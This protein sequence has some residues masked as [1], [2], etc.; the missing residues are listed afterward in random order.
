MS[1]SCGN[2][3]VARSTT[4]P[5]AAG[6]HYDAFAVLLHWLIAALIVLQVVLA[7]RMEGPRTP[8][9]FAV[10][11]LHK[12]IGIT[13]LLLSLLRLGWRLV[14]PPPPLPATLANWERRLARWTHVAF[15]VVMIGMP[16]TGWI[17]VSASRIPLPTLLYGV[18]PW[19]M[20]PGLPELAPAARKAWQSVGEFGHG[21]IIKAGYVLLALHVAGALKHQ[22]LPRDAPV[23]GRMAPGA[24]A[25]PW[26]E[27]RLLLIALGFGSVI[28]FG[29]FVQPPAP[30]LAPR[31]AAAAPNQAPPAATAPPSATTVGSPGVAT[32]GGAPSAS[33]AVAPPRWRVLAG[34]TLGFNSAWSG[35]PVRGRFNRWR[36]EIVFS[37]EAL[38][39]SKVKVA[40]DVAS[41]D[42]GD[43]QRD[44]VLPSDDWLDSAHHPTA[45][46]TATRFRK[47]GDDR[48]E[49][50]GRL[51]LRGRTLPLELPFRLKIAGDRAEAHGTAIVD[52][53]AFGVGQ[54]EFAATDQ[55][56]AKVTIDI[57]LKARTSP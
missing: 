44:A 45:V 11:Q 10:L 38:E 51:E 14:N 5:K 6:A 37:P 47:V 34:S 22:V 27:P 26:R 55:I 28:A 9:R 12:S 20:L 46:F 33:A 13:V 25:A 4:P 2:N 21:A 43:A 17:M 8:E 16:L 57:D 19:P 48:F 53:G 1:N 54:G 3:G 23:L 49:A 36:A 24:T 56:P 50:L 52:R 7:G 42:T 18:V 40:V 15:Y 32:S 35:Q 39:R 31:P 41:I 30:S 29:R